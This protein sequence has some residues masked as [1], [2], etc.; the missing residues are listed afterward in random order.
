MN[1]VNSKITGTPYLTSPEERT[2]FYKL[3][4][5]AIMSQGAEYKKQPRVTLNNRV[6]LLASNIHEFGIKLMYVDADTITLTE[7]GNKNKVTIRSSDYWQLFMGYLNKIF[8]HALAEAL[9]KSKEMPQK[10]SSDKDFTFS[11]KGDKE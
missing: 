10:G 9:A 5:N 7:Y 1:L 2:K 11:S 8:G 4:C 3:M 6:Y